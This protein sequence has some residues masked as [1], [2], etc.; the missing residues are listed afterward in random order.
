LARAAMTA[1]PPVP[2][3]WPLLPQTVRSARRQTRLLAQRAALQQALLPVQ[4]QRGEQEKQQA[5]PRR[6]LLELA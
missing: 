2:Q 1:P 6:Q 3:G 4:P 5:I